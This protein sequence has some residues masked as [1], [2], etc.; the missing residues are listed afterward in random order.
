MKKQLY[1][2]LITLCASFSAF[3]QIDSV[4]IFRPGPGLNDSTDQGGVNGGKDAFVHES[5]PVDNFGTSPGLG[6]TP[7]SDC[8]QTH[9]QSFIQFDLGTLPDTVDSVFVGFQF[10]DQIT[11]CIS[12]CVAD[13]YFAAITQEW[14]EQTVA[15][16]NKPSY[17]TA[18]YGPITISFPDSAGNGEFNI[19]NMYNLWKSGTVTNYGFA[20]YST[21]IGCNN[22]CIMF[23]PYSSDDTTD[24]MNRPYLKVHFTADTTSSTNIGK[25][26]AEQIGLKAYPNPATNELNLTF[27]THEAETVSYVI[28]DMTGRTMINEKKQ[29]SAG[30][31]QIS[32]PT[33]KLAP[34]MYCYRLST[35]DGTVNQKFIRQ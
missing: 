4:I 31:Q 18:F 5:Y 16:G 29:V 22:A 27:T 34:G 32:I 17:D 19:T 20:I 8:N 21:T 7:I 3:S 26:V 13:F 10:L 6:A 11:Y 23:Y 12:N 30:K 24:T 35:K 28:T 33:N 2:L 25:T 15:Y 9:M 14:Y 1:L